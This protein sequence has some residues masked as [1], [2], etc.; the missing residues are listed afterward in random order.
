MDLATLIGILAAFGLVGFSILSGDGAETFIN[1]P[2]MLIVFGGTMGATL[3]CF[4]LKTVVGIM[5]VL[6]KTLLYKGLQSAELIGQLEAMAKKARKEG[7]LSLQQSGGQIEDDFYRT[8]LQLVVDGQEGDTIETI[9][10]IEIDSIG[11]RHRVGADMFK[12]M[13]TYAPAFGMI[14]TIIGLIQ[15]LQSMEDPA[16]IGP[17]MSV[18]LV[19]TFYGAL[20]SNVFFLPLVTKLEQ[21]SAAEISQ[22]QLIMEGLLSIHAGDN[23]RVL[24]QKLSAYI[25][26]ALRQLEST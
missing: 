2:S 14:G 23:P 18:A 12:A 1:L 19:T 21:R 24:L 13:G 9:L 5:G 17:S 7:L 6:K 3:V 16:S 15:M 4:P 20:L 8:G 25:P 11:Q 10:G 22:K 26:P